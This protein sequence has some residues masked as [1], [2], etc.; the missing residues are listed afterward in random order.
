MKDPKNNTG[1]END[2]ETLSSDR[3]LATKNDTAEEEANLSDDDLHG[4]DLDVDNAD[5]WDEAD[6]EDELDE[7][8]LEDDDQLNAELHQ[9][10]ND[11]FG[12]IA[13][14][15]DAATKL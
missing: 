12:S 1:N 2:G 3:V 13:T 6:M 4:R 7:R 8:D 5:E 14:E 11:Q 9:I 15:I 10:K